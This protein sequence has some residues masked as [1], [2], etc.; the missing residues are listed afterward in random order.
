MFVKL[1]NV[2]EQN[3]KLKVV[4]EVLTFPILIIIINVFISSI[5][6][7]GLYFGTFMRGLFE[8]VV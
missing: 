2:L 5:A 1:K 7:L 8:L 3:K 4:L 6:Q